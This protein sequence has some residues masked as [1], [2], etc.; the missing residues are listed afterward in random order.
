MKATADCRKPFAVL[1]EIAALALIA[2]LAGFAL[3]APAMAAPSGAGFTTFD[4]TAQGRLDG[5]NGINCNNYTAKDKVYMSGG[6]TQAGL[7]DGCYYFSVLT[8]GSQ[9]G[10]FVDGAVGNLSDNVVPTGATAGDGGGGDTIA[11]RTFSVADHLIIYPDTSCNLSSGGHNT[12]TQPGSGKTIVQLIAFDDTDNPG[13]VYILAV[14][15]VGATSSSQC[16]Y[17]AFKVRQCTGDD[18]TPPPPPQPL[19]VAKDAATYFD[20]TFTWNITKAVDKTLVEQ[21]GGSATF[22]YTIQVKHDS[23]TDSNWKVDGIIT[24]ANPNTSAGNNAS[25]VAVNDGILYGPVETLG[26]DPNA[27]CVV[28]TSGGTNPLANSSVSLPYTCTYLGAPAAASETNHVHISWLLPASTDKTA[29]FFLQGLTFDQPN[30]ID[31]CVTV[32]DPSYSAG[33][34]GTACTAGPNNPT[35]YTYARTIPVPTFN[36]MFYDNTA[37]FTTLDTSATRSASK[38]VEVCGPAKTGAL[39]MG[40]W[41]NKNGQG[42]IKNGGPTSGTCNSGTWLRQYAPFQDLNSTATCT[43]VATYVYNVIKAANAAGVS[44]NTMLK[45]QM[46]ATALDVYFSDSTLGGNK[47]NAPAPIG[48]VS[49]DLTMICK[50]IDST[51]G[52]ATCSGSFEDVRSA[53]GTTTPL[54]TVSNMLS[55]AAS[56]SNAG[57]SPWYANVKSTQQLAKDAFDAINNQVAFAP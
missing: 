10:G 26:P 2:T 11:N 25:G 50:M 34:L 7:S 24:V 54:M 14:C 41:Q 36:C 12:G 46:L 9:N 22:N 19:T 45:A 23:G 42:I 27:A 20:R 21:I 18:C 35:S 56:Q 43:T 48:G 31:E 16:K 8:P 53:F 29:D 55:Y 17:D 52:T 30:L 37:T 49:I 4:N 5:P 33:T 39:T 40:Y 28:N 44:M 3:V 38:K 51:N 47:I 1:V 32:T 57:G 6:P 13:G 15:Q